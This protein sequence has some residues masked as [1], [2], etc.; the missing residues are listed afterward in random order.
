M[1]ITFFRYGRSSI[2]G[3]SL[4]PEEQ[5]AQTAQEFRRQKSK[6]EL[7]ADAIDGGFLA[8]TDVQLAV[9]FLHRNAAIHIAM[10]CKPGDR[11]CVTS[12]DRL[13]ESTVDACETLEWAQL[14]QIGLV[15]V[16]MGVDTST[17]HGQQFIK[18]LG[19][20]KKQDR[21]EFSRRGIEINAR[22]REQGLIAGGRAPLG[23]T[24][25]EI[26]L[27]DGKRMK[28]YFP[29]AE[30]R[31]YAQRIIT[32]HDEQGLS[33]ERIAVKFWQ[34]NIVQPRTGTTPSCKQAVLNYYHRAKMGWPLPG[35]VKWQP[36][37]FN[38]KLSRKS[39]G[40]LCA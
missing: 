22:R 39:L 1:P 40:G 2:D 24:L 29:W 18:L 36:P 21:N 13:V 37:E 23:Y 7:P 3:K 17:P 10:K 9:K 35:G 38:Y 26:V 11:I 25:R 4:S 32:M 14:M 19:M 28:Y 15:F 27:V 8:D 30:E 34:H 6:G 31:Q 16:D 33:F 12:Y 20:V 5:A